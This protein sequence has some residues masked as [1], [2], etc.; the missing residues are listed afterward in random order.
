MPL[1]ASPEVPR[2]D[3]ASVTPDRWRALAGERIF[4]GHQ[5]V[6]GNIVDGIAA[7][8]AEHPGIPLHVI[9]TSTLDST[10]GPG[11][12]HARIGTNG[13][14]ASKSA[15]FDTIVGRGAPAIGV[16]K[17]CYEDVDARSNPDSLFAAY[18]RAMAALRARD[19]HFI[20]VHVTMPLTTIEGRRELV[21]ARLRGRATKRDLNVTRNRYNALLRQAYAGKEPVFDLA[22]FESTRADGSRAFFMR[23]AD[24]VYILDRGYTDDGGH[25]NV[26]ARR[27]AA[28]EF[29]AV[30][31]GLLAAALPVRGRA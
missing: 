16:L 23:G 28:R 14:P 21:M 9:D 17:Y 1:P 7:V 12:Y 3:F 2:P 18:E 11:I 10:A 29:L 30:L 19:P 5:S 15:A 31:A 13:N 20:M 6:G 22:R 27:A 25:L 4:F 8:L 24:T 26:A